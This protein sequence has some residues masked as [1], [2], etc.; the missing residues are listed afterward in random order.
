MRSK[1][2]HIL[3]VSTLV[4]LA[5]AAAVLLVGRSQQHTQAKAEKATTTARKASND[6]KTKAPRTAL[7][8]TNKTLH[9][10][11]VIQRKQTTIL[12]R[13]GFAVRGKNGV[14]GPA[15][16]PGRNA[17]VP[18][19]LSDVIDGLSPKLTE[20]L[21]T[22]AEVADA[23]GSAC[24]GPTGP[25]GQNGRDVTQDMVDAAVAKYCDAHGQCRGP[26]GQPGADSQVPGPQGP[27]GQPG[28][29]STVPGPQGPPGAPAPPPPTTFA[30]G[31]ANADGTFTCTAVG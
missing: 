1:T 7:A 27:A 30:C 11:K 2:V 14:P 8:K 4:G 6:A 24:V 12:V 23:C 3:F 25:A 28:A 10:V 9:A 20:R 26:T 19:T 17:V 18:F 15:G 21:P 5:I 13:Q 22:P 31:P 16:P 29:D